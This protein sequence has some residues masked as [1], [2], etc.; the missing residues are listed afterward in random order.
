M[1]ISD[2]LREHLAFSATRHVLQVAEN[3]GIKYLDKNA[4]SNQILKVMHKT[5]TSTRILKV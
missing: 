3:G 5:V 2:L 1:Q 4:V